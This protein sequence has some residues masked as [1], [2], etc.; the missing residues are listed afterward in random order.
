[1]RRLTPISQKQVVVV[2]QDCSPDAVDGEQ[3]KN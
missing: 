2:T 3:V 1:L